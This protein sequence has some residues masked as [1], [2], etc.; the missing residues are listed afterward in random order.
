M[1]WSGCVDV[2]GRLGKFPRQLPPSRRR[3]TPHGWLVTPLLGQIFRPGV[4]PRVVF[5]PGWPLSGFWVFHYRPPAPPG[6]R[7]PRVSWSHPVHGV[8]SFQSLPLPALFAPLLAYYRPLLASTSSRRLP[9]V[10]GFLPSCLYRPFWGALGCLI[11]RRGS[12]PTGCWAHH[13]RLPLL[14]ACPLP[15]GVSRGL[16]IMALLASTSSACLSASGF[17]PPVG[18]FFPVIGDRLPGCL[19]APGV[20]ALRLVGHPRSASMS[21]PGPFCARPV[22]C[23]GGLYLVADFCLTACLSPVC[24][25]PA[26]P[27]S[28]VGEHLRFHRRPSSPGCLHCF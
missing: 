7:L 2:S 25:A 3:S 17:S 4:P 1:D 8:P 28:V 13:V 14:G 20:P 18:P 10:G 26:R 21:S 15:R 24:L 16:G 12:P 23:P 6:F 9:C 19:V 5:A 11:A 27:L 22:F